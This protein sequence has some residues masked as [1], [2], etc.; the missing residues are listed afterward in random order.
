MIDHSKK[1]EI[2]ALGFEYAEYKKI[3]EDLFNPANITP[4]I[5]TPSKFI[6]Y[7]VIRLKNLEFDIENSKAHRFELLL[8]LVGLTHGMIV[9]NT[10]NNKSTENEVM[11]MISSLM[12]KLNKKE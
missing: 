7:N 6:E 4:D 9:S 5:N 1:D 11:N 12:N 3:I 2:E 10:P 8:Y